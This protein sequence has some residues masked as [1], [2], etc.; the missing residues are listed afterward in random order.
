MSFT[1]GGDGVVE[2]C[3]AD[4]ANH[5][6][7]RVP[8]ESHL[9]AAQQRRPHSRGFGLVETVDDDGQPASGA[10]CSR[11]DG[12]KEFLKGGQGLARYGDLTGE[13][14]E[15]LSGA[16]APAV[17]QDT[18][19]ACRG[20]RGKR[21]R[22][23]C[24]AES[25][26]AGDDRE[27]G[28]QVIGDVVSESGGVTDVGD[29]VGQRQRGGMPQ[30]PQPPKHGGLRQGSRGH[31][32]VGGAQQRGG[33]A[34]ADLLVCLVQ[35]FGDVSS[36]GDDRRGLLGQRGRH[37]Y[38]RVIKGRFEA[39][40]VVVSVAQV[41][42]RVGFGEHPPKPAFGS[43]CLMHL[44][45]P[46]FARLGGGPL[47]LFGQTLRGQDEGTEV[48]LAQQDGISDEEMVEL[49]LRGQVQLHFGGQTAEPRLV[50]GGERAPGP[51]HE[52]GDAREVLLG[53]LE[54]ILDIGSAGGTDGAARGD[55]PPLGLPPEA[56]TGFTQGAGGLVDVEVELDPRLLGQG[57]EATV[58]SV[59]VGHG[60]PAQQ[61]EVVPAAS[62]QR[63]ELLPIQ[64]GHRI[65]RPL[66]APAVAGAGVVV[67]GIHLD[68]GP[69]VQEDLKQRLDIVLIGGH[70]DGVALASHGE[71]VQ[72]LLKLTGSDAVNVEVAQQF[73][74]LVAESVVRLADSQAA[75]FLLRFQSLGELF[76][77]SVGSFGGSGVLEPA[78]H[79]E[80][81]GVLGPV[82]VP[83][84][85]A[86]PFSCRQSSAARTPRSSTGSPAEW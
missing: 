84:L 80:I 31:G 42:P 52:V 55:V 41:V 6:Y 24:F 10:L 30:G 34:V 49:D 16:Q 15:A 26:V 68:A 43:R 25:G 23:L 78:N 67:R 44:G 61:L 9:Q 28:R 22:Q 35:K 40:D 58:T 7:G 76:D 5:E 1:P 50:T 63:G 72:E 77:D 3:L 13:V 81:H 32:A 17:E 75:G 38:G 37:G 64:T 18:G 12:G 60:P 73:Q 14:V 36:R 83:D 65:A 66:L 2:E 19:G 62:W 20:R 54:G 21:R 8:L 45:N 48:G 79:D 71:V 11:V 27:S 74:D 33:L 53:L 86:T 69:L 56:A 59:C 85:H 47:V 51:Q 82:P 70:H 57:D 39:G 4:R 29:Q 46:A